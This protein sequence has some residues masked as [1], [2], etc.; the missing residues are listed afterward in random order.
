MRNSING[1]PVSR[2][3]GPG[4]L[5]LVQRALHRA[6]VPLLAMTVC[7]ALGACSIVPKSGP[8]TAAIDQEAKN[9]AAPFLLIPVSR[10]ALAELAHVAPADFRP[11]ATNQPAPD[12]MIHRGDKV[13]VTLWEYGSGL[14]GP[15]PAANQATVGLVGAQSATVPNQS[16]DQNGTIIVPFAGEIRAVGRTTR[17]VEAAII[18]A[19]RGKA[20]N[21][22]ALVQIVQTTDNAVTVTGDVNHPGRFQLAPAGTRLL[23]A[24]SEAGGTTGK[25][26]D[27][28]VQLTRDNDVRST[29]LTVIHADP[30]QN[31]YLKP[32]DVLTLDQEPQSVVVLGA[33]NRNL[34]VPFDKTNMTLAE[35]LGAGGGLSDQQADPYGVYILRYETLETAKTLRTTPLPDYLATGKPVPVVYQINLRSADGLMLSQNFMMRDRDLVYVANAPSVQ[36]GKLAGM[37][38]GIAAI[39]KNNTNNPY[40]HY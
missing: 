25:A 7:L 12:V 37:F 17:Q 6:L 13:S 20:T 1:F 35:T 11:L 9:E 28:L 19:L 5:A 30:M 14:L 24:L 33:T 27:M 8:L 32:G 31:I 40:G 23:E 16:V 2:P 4:H 29:R 15:V 21:A 26:R 36:I 18:Q 39:F 34:V 22:Q 10:T 38:N 3:A